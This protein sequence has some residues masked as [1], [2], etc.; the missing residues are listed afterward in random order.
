MAT[1]DPAID[2]GIAF[3]LWHKRTLLRGRRW[4]WHCINLDNRSIV[5]AG[6]S[7]GYS[8]QQ[9]AMHGINIARGTG[10]ETPVHLVF[11]QR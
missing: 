3:Q 8:S 1:E 9:A 6:Q 11:P 2:D 7:A 10:F 4:F 5:F